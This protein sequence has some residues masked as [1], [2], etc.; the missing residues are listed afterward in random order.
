L[1]DIPGAAD[2]RAV[3]QEHGDGN[4]R[5]VC[6]TREPRLLTKIVSY[7]IVE[8]HASFLDQ[9]HHDRCHKG[10]PNAA[11]QETVIATHAYTMF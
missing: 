3:G 4:V 6:Q 1:T 11:G 7:S 8:S 9:L 10:L 2:T 5:P